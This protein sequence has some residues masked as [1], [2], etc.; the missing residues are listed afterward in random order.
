MNNYTALISFKVDIEATNIESAEH[1]AK[2]ALPHHFDFSDGKGGSGKFLRGLAPVV[3]L[4]E[5]EDKQYDS[6][7]RNR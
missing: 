4:R 3:Y 5:E 7:W 2:Q 1:I 6:Y